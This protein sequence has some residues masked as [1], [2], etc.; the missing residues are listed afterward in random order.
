[1]TEPTRVTIDLEHP[2]I[3][4]DQK[5]EAVTLRKPASGEMRGLTLQALGQSDVTS[6]ITLIPRISEPPLTTPEVEAMQV[7]DFAACGN[8]VFDFFLKPSQREAIKTLLGS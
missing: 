7:E 2:I 6:L 8:A 1:M 5:I 4:G 3:R